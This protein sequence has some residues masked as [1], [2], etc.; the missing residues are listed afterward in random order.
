MEFLVIY[1]DIR[2]KS[3]PVICLLYA[4]VPVAY[5][6]QGQPS[7]RRT[8]ACVVSALSG[9]GDSGGMDE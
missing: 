3:T 1:S 8:F 7:C 2:S 6:Q 4:S 9:Y 5:V